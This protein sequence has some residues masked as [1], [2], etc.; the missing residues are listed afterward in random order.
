LYADPHT[1]RRSRPDSNFA[2]VTGVF[3]GIVLMEARCS[4][5]RITSSHP[6][7]SFAAMDYV[8]HSPLVDIGESVHDGV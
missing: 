6:L 8:D 3:T 5:P 1:K 4:R 2:L 7:S